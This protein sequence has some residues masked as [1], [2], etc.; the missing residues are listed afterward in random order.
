MNLIV[1][2]RQRHRP[3]SIFDDDDFI[4]GFFFSNARTVEHQV[5][6]SAPRITVKPLPPQTGDAHFLGLVCKW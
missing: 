2:N 3:S 6:S 5:K 1:R 4:G